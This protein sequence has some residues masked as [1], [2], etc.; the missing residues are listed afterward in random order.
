M[1]PFRRT[2]NY[3]GAIPR[4][5]ITKILHHNN[6]LENWSFIYNTDNSD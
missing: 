3:L 1:E 6:N 4:D 5:Y 2:I